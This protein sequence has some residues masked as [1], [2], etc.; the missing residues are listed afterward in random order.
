[1]KKILV[2]LCMLCTTYCIAQTDSLQL[3][4]KGYEIAK[5]L[6]V[7][8]K[9][10]L[11][12]NNNT[13]VQQDSL[14]LDLRNIISTKDIL[15]KNDKDQ[16]DI[17]NQQQIFLKENLNIYQKEFNRRDKFWN[18]PWFGAILGIAGTVAIIHVID[19]SL[20]Q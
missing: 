4:K 14:I 6:N 17:L 1:M 7:E 3:Y 11:E 12:L 16:I 5:Q 19:Y 8:Y 15:L 2:I 20:P 18:K 9:L 10:K 13:I